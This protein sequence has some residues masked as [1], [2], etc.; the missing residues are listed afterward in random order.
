MHMLGWVVTMTITQPTGLKKSKLVGLKTKVVISLPPDETLALS[1]I[2]FL[3]VEALYAIDLFNSSLSLLPGRYGLL[4]AYGIIIGSLLGL[5]GIF[6]RVKMLV[7]FTLII[8]G[9]EAVLRSLAIYSMFLFDNYNTLFLVQNFVLFTFAIAGIWAATLVDTKHTASQ[10][11]LTLEKAINGTS[12][13]SGYVIEMHNVHKIYNPGAVKVHALR[14]INLA[15]RK[16]EFISIMGPSGSGK[17]TLLNLLGALDKPTSGEVLIDGVNISKLNSDQLAELRNVKIGFVFQSYNLINRSKVLRN[18]EL[19]AIVKGTPKE[20]RE[21]RAKMLLTT[22]GLGDT[23]DRRPRLLSGG[24]QQRVAIARAL[25][26][27]PQIILADEPTGNLDSKA[28]EEVM[29]Y[30]RR[31]NEEFNTT[32]IVVTHDRDVANLTDRILH[33][34]DGIIIGEEIVR[35]DKSD[36]EKNN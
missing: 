19:P 14:G 18:V 22:L 15:V 3:V 29:K 36:D 13:K 34:K 25:I 35:R 27:N 24:Q 23:W 6:A 8:L 20:E 5:L 10:A 7:Q 28:G 11:E 26:N 31:M 4:L 30:L 9:I 12:N 16:G 17:S 2:T 21:K 32:V 1:L 33:I